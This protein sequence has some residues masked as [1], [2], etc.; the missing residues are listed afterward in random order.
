M[1]PDA[2]VGRGSRAPGLRGRVMLSFAAGAAIVSLVL[3]VSVFTISRGYLL[4]QRERSAQR[5]ADADADFVASRLAVPGMTP[6][7]ALSAVDPPADTILLL[8]WRGG[9][10]SSDP[11]VPARAPSEH[12]AESPR[13][14]APT[15][16]T[17]IRNQPYL[18]TA[19][20]LDGGTLYE[21]AP[22]VELRDTLRVLRTVLVISG[23]AATLG[24]ALLGLWA[25]GRVLRPLR[26]LAGTAASI[27]GGNLDSRLPEQGD[28]DLRPIL[29]SFNTMV[30]SLQRRIERERRF[31]GDV[32][33][34]LRTPLTT[35][36]TSVG[37]LGKHAEE[38]P[39]RPRTALRLVEGELAHLRGMVEDL[40]TL[41]R[42]EAGLHHDDEAPV[43]T[44]DLLAHVLGERAAPVLDADGDGRVRGHKLALIRAFTNLVDNA[45][46]HGGGV[47]GVELSTSAD[48]VVVAVDDAGPGVP[49]GERE[50][51][52]ER[53]AT[54]RAARGSTSGNG[55]GLALVA[56]AVRAN[57]GTVECVTAPGGGARFVVRL[58]R[59]HGEGDGAVAASAAEPQT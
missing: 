1:S 53:F 19:M 46:Q 38:M 10:T 31:V 35:L 36:V 6:A 5:L 17:T 51:I 44:R 8:D 22:I 59:D 12:L 23:L 32:T 47:T 41:A 52:F 24:G 4:G 40:L 58:P 43:S 34:E 56:E 15:R 11:A 42:T 30:D 14:G 50:R 37:L 2:R 7:A 39:E 9:W 21:F 48:S 28:R 45:E 33:H 26:S 20:P 18:V 49:E 16:P 57:G 13:E 25:S 3:T 55:L 29:S 27:A 54:G